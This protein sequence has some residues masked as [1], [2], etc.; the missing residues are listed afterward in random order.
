MSRWEVVTTG[1]LDANGYNGSKVRV[2]SQIES[3]CQYGRNDKNLAQ[4]QLLLLEMERQ[5]LIISAMIERVRSRWGLPVIRQIRHRR[6][7]FRPWLTWAEHVE[8]G[9]YTR[10]MP[11]LQLDDPMAYQKF[12]R[13][14]P[15]LFQELEQRITAE[16]QRDRTWMRDPLRQGVKLAVTLRLLATGDSYTTLQYAFRVASSTINK[17]V[18][19]VGDAIIRAYWDQVMRCPTLPEDWLQVKSVFRWRWNIPQALGALDG[20]H[21]P[22]YSALGP[23]GWRL[24]VPLGGGGAAG[25]RSDAQIFKHPNLRHKIE[26]GSIGFPESESLGIGGPK[27]NFSSSGMM[28]SPSSS[29]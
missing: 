11:R 26:D 22:L 14:P 18:P 3:R 1:Y 28:L 12:I 27:V 5:L 2:T 10:L 24:Q 23:R 9:Q 17:F 15:E 19:E 4:L 7:R 20:K 6:Y 16:L 21:I 29:G 13:M 25:S 8:D